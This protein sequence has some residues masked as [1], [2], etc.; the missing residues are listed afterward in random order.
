MILHE[1][2]GQ[3]TNQNKNGNTKDN[4]EEK[5]SDFFYFSP[6]QVY[7]REYRTLKP[8]Q[9]DKEKFE[10]KVDFMK[11]RSRIHKFKSKGKR[12]SVT[13]RLEIA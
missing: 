13:I 8:E 12:W 10:P 4:G 11:T 2:V 1:L 9:I 6:F 3:K 7:S 5:I